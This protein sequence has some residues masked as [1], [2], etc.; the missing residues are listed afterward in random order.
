MSDLL[1]RLYREMTN[2]CGGTADMTH[3]MVVIASTSKTGSHLEERKHA[4]VHSNGRRIRPDDS[5]GIV[6]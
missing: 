4:I 2:F 5:H 3:R 1:V 6:S